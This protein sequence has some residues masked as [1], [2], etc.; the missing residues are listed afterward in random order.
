VLESKYKKLPKYLSKQNSEKGLF[1]VNQVDASAKYLFATEGPIDAFFLKNG[2]AVAGI[3]EGR[4]AL[5]T[6][7]QREQLKAFPLHE[8]IWVLDN[9]WIDRASKNK[10]N[11]LAKQGYKV[12]IWPEKLKGFKDLNEV[13][14]A[15][16]LD[17]ISDKFI[18]KNV[19]SDVKA[20][21]LLSQIS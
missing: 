16:K 17:A 5:L 21:L 8:V 3:T 19:Y 18:L 9:Q 7:K 20:R 1:G 13:C 6:D 10:T 14:I 4:G 11:I 15:H 12:F 2:V